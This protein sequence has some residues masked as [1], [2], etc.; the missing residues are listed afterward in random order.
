M[1]ITSSLASVDRQSG[2]T[3]SLHSQVNDPLSLTEIPIQ[4]S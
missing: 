1:A 4:V 2:L 3:Y